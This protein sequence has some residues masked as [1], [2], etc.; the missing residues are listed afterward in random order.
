MAKFIGRRVNLGIAKE[1]RGVGAAAT[2]W[3]PRIGLSFDD[4]TDK[5]VSQDG[6]GGIEEANESFIIEKYGMGSVDGEVRSKSIGLF[7]TAIMGA[8]P[9]FTNPDPV[10]GQATWSSITQTNIHQSLAFQVSDPLAD[11]MFKLVMLN[12]FELNVKVGEV[13]KFKCDFMSK[14]SATTSA[15]V[16]YASDSKFNCNNLTFKLADDIASLTA[17]SNIPLKSLNL[18][19]DKNLI[20]VHNTGSSEP[21]DICNQQFSVEGNIE[22]LHEAT[23]YKGYMTGN[24]YKAMRITLTNPT[25]ITGA[26]Y[27]NIQIDLPRVHFQ[28]WESSK[29]LNSLSTEK[30][31]FQGLKDV[32]NSQTAIHQIILTNAQ[33]TNVY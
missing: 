12:T 29:E 26:Y 13:A 2:F 20:R 15:T 23:T 8:S 3:L 1:T 5:Y 33:L 31:N 18:K 10:V 25:A 22:L 7:F 17:A 9:S 11:L 32:A 19:I 14:P 30:F 6:Y 24:T 27:P 21:N 28:N 16:A 4:K